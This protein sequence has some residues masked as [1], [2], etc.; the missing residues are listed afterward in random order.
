MPGGQENILPLI[1][2]STPVLDRIRDSD[3]DNETGK[4]MAEVIVQNLEDPQSDEARERS[5]EVVDSMMDTISEELGVPR[6][7]LREEFAL[8][9]DSVLRADVEDLLS[10]KALEGLGMGET[11]DEDNTAPTPAELPDEDESEE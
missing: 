10:D 6:E 11:E 1:E 8:E 5:S 9:V 7:Q 4:D 2:R 3:S